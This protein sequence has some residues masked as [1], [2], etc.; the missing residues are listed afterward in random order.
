MRTRLRAARRLHRGAR[1]AHARARPGESASRRTP[2]STRI[3]C[4]GA[5]SRPRGRRT[6]ASPTA[7]AA[8]LRADLTLMADSLPRGGRLAAR[9]RP[10]PRRRSAGPRCSASTSR[11][12]TCASTASVHEGVVAEILRAAG[13]GRRLPRAG[14]GRRASRCSSASWPARGRWCRPDAAYSPETAEALAVFDSARRLQA[15]LGREACDVY[16]VSMTAGASDLLEPLLLAREAGL[17]GR[18]GDA[19]RS[20]LQVV[21]LFETIDD[22]NRCGDL[23]RALFALPVYR[24]HLAAWGDLQQ[25]MVGYSD[26][27]KDGGFVTANW[28]LYRAQQ[29]LADGLPRARASASPVPRPRRRRRPR[30]RPD[31][32]RDPGPA[33]GHAG[34]GGCASPSRARS[35][36]RATATRS[37]ALRH[38]EQMT[39]RGPARVAHRRRGP[40][41][42]SRNGWSAMTPPRPKPRSTPTCR[43]I[44]DDPALMA[45]FRADHAHRPGRRPAHRLAAGEAQ[46]RRAPRGPARHPVGLQLDAE[47]QRPARAGTAW[48]RPS[49]R[50]APRTGRSRHPAPHDPR[51]AVLPL[52]A[53][54]RADGPRPLRPRGGAAVRL[55]GGRGRGAAVLAAME[56]EWERTEKAPSSP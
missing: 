29:A 17:R 8:E 51:L 22:L 20:D 53:G 7:R 9:R 15:E 13:V 44:R 27:N 16:I 38:L 52:A 39:E 4:G 48:A 5:P 33:A 43:T 26:S 37:I 2:W 23:M 25:V 1:M 47:P 45:Y 14:R 46:G 41:T 18:D 50:C 35:R 32:P 19:V 10:A 40:A 49:R 31:Q 21:P 55:A 24:R 3:A 6:T 11:A 36:S 28:K 30:R 12:S 34:A 54:E 42:P 56:E